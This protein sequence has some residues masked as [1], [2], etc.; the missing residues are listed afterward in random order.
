MGA[1]SILTRSKTARRIA[2]GVSSGIRKFASPK[3]ADLLSEGMLAIGRVTGWIVSTVL[4]PFL[5]WTA[6]TI[7]AGLVG[8]GTFVMNFDFNTTDE[9]IEKMF[10]AFKLRWYGQ[11]GDAVGGLMGWTVGGLIP[12]LV[13]F[14]FNPVMALYVLE[15]VGEEA[16]DELLGEITV[17]AQMT[18]SNWT[19]EFGLRLFMGVRAL[20]KRA[21]KGDVDTLAGE[22]I[23]AILNAYPALVAKVAGWGEKGSKPW[24]ISRK[25]EDKM[26]KIQNK[27][28]KEFAE[29]A[30]DNFGDSLIEAGFVVAMGID[31]FIAQSKIQK[32]AVLGKQRVV[33]IAYD[34]KDP[35]DTVIFAGPEELVKTQIMSHMADYYSLQEKDVGLI[36]GGEPI[37]STITTPGLPYMRI[38]FSASESKKV[39]PTYIDIKN[40]SRS[41]VDNW[42][43]LKAACG[44]SKGYM[45]GSYWVE[46]LLPDNNTISCFGNT[47]NEAEEMIDRLLTF[48]EAGDKPELIRWRRGG[49]LHKGSTKLYDSTYKKA[50][51]QYPW[52]VLIV[53]PQ[54]ILN[55]ENGRAN[56]SGIYKDNEALIPLWTATKPPDF[57]EK[58][59]E[60]FRTPG[61]N[62]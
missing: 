51:R 18:V 3:A 27:Y 34:R 1:L 47:E 45:W 10:E 26:E 58:I 6:T 62:A 12:G 49:T 37:L 60:L 42:A 38:F 46:A 57:A 56:R 22:G 16:Y 31:S 25:I 21:A 53:N 23:L 35:T 41:K 39:K 13:L 50:R 5:Q 61:A 7:W 29:N 59:T 17:L 24:I 9:D 15:Q 28:L 48:S 19:R 32:D 54:R 55:E 43:E 4:A 52:E 14:R 30:W 20:I 33:Q 8:V 44:G 11:L 36:L 2:T 40:I